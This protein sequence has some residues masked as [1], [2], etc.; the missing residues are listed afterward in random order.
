MRRMYQA[1]LRASISRSIGARVCSTV[2]ASLSKRAIG[3]QRVEIGERPPD[4]A[5]N[6][7]EERLGGR[8]E[9]ADIEVGVEEERRDIGAVQNVLQIVG[10]R[11]LPLQGLLEL[12]VEG[13][14]LL[15]E[16]LQ[17]LLRCQQLLVRG[18]VFL[19]D[20]QRL[21]VDR[22]LLFVRNLKVAD[23]ALEFG[24]GGF[25]LLL[26]LGDPRN[27]LRRDGT[28]SFRLLLR[29]VDEADQQ[30]LFAIAQNRLDGDAER[31]SLPSRFIRPPA[32]TIRVF[33]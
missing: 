9:E 2:R 26:K 6:D 5:R 30:Q 19:V 27:L 29:F 15:V 20:G 28:A 17:F 14:K 18:L 32:T 25:E 16:R 22:L 31:T 33:S 24:S 21:F 3:S 4:V 1:P 23:R 8:R 7:A 10:G 13:G 11:A 12:A